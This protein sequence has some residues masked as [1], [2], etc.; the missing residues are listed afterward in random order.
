MARQSR[1][2][3]GL[4]LAKISWR[5]LRDHKALMAFPVMGI[6]LALIIG[7]LFTLPG[8]LLITLTDVLW[9]AIILFA[10]SGYLIVFTGVFVGVGLC[11]TADK[12]LRG[13][14][15]RFADGIHV[16]RERLPEIAQWALMLVTV[17]LVIGVI[18]SKL[19]RIGGAVV[20]ALA[21]LAWSLVSFLAIPVITFEGVGPIK[22]LKRSSSLFQQR[23]GQQVVGQAITGGVVGVF[24][25]LPGVA[26]VTIGAIMIGGGTVAAG[27][28]LLVI[29]AVLMII[30]L[31]VSGTLSQILSVALYHYAADGQAVGPFSSDTL[32]GVVRPRRGARGV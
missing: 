13:E 23:W 30:G 3:A 11:A 24:T 5:T 28:A 1:F 10:L 6:V 32:Q 19:G 21:G 22:A 27:A 17:A 31:V 18:Q 16:A 12:V 29:G 25:L 7:L 8:I 15:A 14:D 4:E 2:R 9:A 26:L 20:G